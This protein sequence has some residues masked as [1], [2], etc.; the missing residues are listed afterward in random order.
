MLRIQL[1]SSLRPLTPEVRAVSAAKGSAG[2]EQGVVISGHMI[3]SPDRT[4]PRFPPSAEKPVRLAMERIL[5]YRDIGQKDLAITGGARGADIIGAELCLARGAAVWLLLPLPEPEFLERSV[6]LPGSDWVERFHA[7]ARRS[8]V[9]YQQDELGPAPPGQNPFARNNTW[10][11][12]QGR[13]AVG[14]ERLFGLVVWDEWP[15]SREGG[16]A[17]FVAKANQSGVPVEIV[18]PMML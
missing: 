16:A 2:F 3:D 13:A 14:D 10:C 11:L 15:A 7:L 12:D 5:A 18:N 9:R 6:R 1:L 8:I 17:D 4:P